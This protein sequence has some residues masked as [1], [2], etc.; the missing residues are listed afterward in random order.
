MKPAPSALPDFL[1]ELRPRISGD[2]RTD[3]YNKVLYSTDSSI[4]Q[5]MPFGVLM[6]KTMEDVHAAVELAAKYRIPLLP[7][8][9]GSSLAGQA[10]NAALVVDFTKHLDDIL[11]INPEEQWVRVQPGRVLDELNIEL[12]PHGL[13]FGPDPA[14]GQRAAMAGIVSNNSTGAHSILYGMTVE[15]VLEIKG[16][17]SDGSPFHF[18]SMDD[19][20]FAQMQQRSGLEGQIYREIGDII[21][22]HKSTIQTAT[23]RH[24]RRTGGYGLDRLVDGVSHRWTRDSQINLAKLLSGAE[25]SLAVISEIKLN[26]VPKP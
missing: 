14:S 15:H 8:T 20:M 3:D 12:A 5:V 26:L 22:N 18:R 19:G 1:N 13:Q 17:L 7:R 9:G 25:G 21:T 23:P 10:V 16:F 24:W 4:F 2:L 6:P 11:E